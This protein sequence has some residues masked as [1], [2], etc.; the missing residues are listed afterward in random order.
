MK[1]SR[2]TTLSVRPC[3]YSW[4]QSGNRRWTRTLLLVRLILTSRKMVL[5]VP[6]PWYQRCCRHS[7]QA[8][9]WH[10]LLLWPW[11]HRPPYSRS[12]LTTVPQDRNLT[13][14]N[15]LHSETF[16]H[17]LRIISRATLRE[18][19]WTPFTLVQASND[20][21]SAWNLSLYLHTMLSR[22]SQ[23]STREIPSATSP[24]LTTRHPTLQR[25]VFPKL[26][27]FLHL[28]LGTRFLV[29]EEICNIPSITPQWSSSD[30]AKSSWSFS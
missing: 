30:I 7:W 5:F 24:E 1:T 25:S 14:L 28:N 12:I 17:W 27:L 21:L 6:R 19:L 29:V 4:W 18:M 2:S 8:I 26:P 20:C 13:L 15:N 16:L 22:F 3:Y 11:C 9:F 23:V 10:A